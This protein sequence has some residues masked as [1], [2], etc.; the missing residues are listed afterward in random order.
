MVLLIN[1][2]RG[3]METAF[4]VDRPARYLDKEAFELLGNMDEVV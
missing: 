2:Y 1:A 4:A 3:V